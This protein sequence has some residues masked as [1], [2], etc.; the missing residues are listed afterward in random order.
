MKLNYKKAGFLF[1]SIIQASFSFSQQTTDNKDVTSVIPVVKLGEN[2]TVK[3]GGFLRTEYNIDSR[4]TVGAVDDLFSFFPYPEAKDAAG[5]D[6]NKVVRQNFSAE[7]TR[8]NALFTG[9][10]V[11]GAKSSSFF[12]FD[13]T[14]GAATNGTTTAPFGFRFRHAYVKLNWT[15]S[16]V[17]FGRTWNPLSDI[18]F[19]SV[20]GLNTGIPFRPFGRGDQ[21]RFTYKASESVSILAAA[22]IQ[23]EFK[24]F[25]YV[26]ATAATVVVNNTNDVRANTIPDLHLQLHYKSGAIFA[27]LF[28][29]Y[30]V[31]RP[32]IVSKGTGGIF[33]TTESVNSYTLGGFAR[34]TENK[35]TIQ[36][37]GLYGQN[38]AELF[39][40]GGYAVTSVDA[41]NGK[42]EYTPSK[43]VSSWINAT[44]G[45]D[46]VV[47]LFAG[48]QK[49]LGFND[50][51]LS[52]A[53]TF[54]GRWQDVDHIYRIAPSI[55]YNIGRLS[56]GAELDYNVA[57]YGTVD[58]A[59]KG[60]VKD[61]KEIAG[62][63]GTLAATFLF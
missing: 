53:G 15:N 17:L 12:E 63:R 36:G 14:G 5:D 41:V 19:P 61:A 21:L 22:L 37:S 27:G 44:Y 9:P 45:K 29:E 23:T 3:F 46:V 49:N 56:L 4:R 32:T 8:F 20:I 38:L 30:K 48:Y 18:I 6:Q 16:E 24:S 62:V 52:G 59:N 25:S 40:Q 47:G 26:D 57:A 55:K 31:I 11:L 28:S 60:K 39:Q 50:N 10:D 54:L 51:I 13:F 33:K 1:L 34:Y 2:V 7:A 42:R 43:A 58:Y 35:F